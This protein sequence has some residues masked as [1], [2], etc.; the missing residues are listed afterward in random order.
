MSISE[1]EEK[2]VFVA[3]ALVRDN[4]KVLIARRKS[5]VPEFDGKWEIP[6][7]CVEHNETPEQTAVRELKEET[8]LDVELTTLI[9]TAI[10]HWNDN[11]AGKYKVI[12]L[13]Y[14]A[15]QIGGELDHSDPEI[16]ELVWFTEE[17]A[18]KLDALP[19]LDECIKLFS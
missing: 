8:G 19:G 5:H 10:T 4:G 12:L 9:P 13:C 11:A 6:G 18:I 2:V 7:G 15:R 1:S 17:E 16:S 14:E 3:G